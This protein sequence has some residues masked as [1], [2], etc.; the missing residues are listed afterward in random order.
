MEMKMPRERV[1]NKIVDFEKGTVTFQF[2][3]K[4]LTA[5][6]KRP[7]TSTIVVDPAKFPA[8]IQKRFTLNGVAQKLGDSY[9]DSEDG[10]PVDNVKELIERLMK[11]DWASRGGGG[12][13]TSYLLRALV[14]LHDGKH[15][16][17]PKLT[18]EQ[19]RGWLDQQSDETKK[20]LQTQDGPVKA[21]IERMKAEDAAKRAA[22]TAEG[23]KGKEFVSPLAGLV[24]GNATK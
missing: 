24:K 5:D 14:N 12:E 17:L 13:R 4:A 9:A 8:A 23:A 11:G 22:A 16:K 21:E 1:A 6:G 15:G 3:G 2:L 19:I 20:G 10:T 18:E 7:V